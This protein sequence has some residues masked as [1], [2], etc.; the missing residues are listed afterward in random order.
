MKFKFFD[1]LSVLGITFGIGSVLLGNALEG[2][3]INS[4]INIPA[5][6]IVLGG[7]L[8]AT[9]LQ[10]P[11]HIFFKSLSMLIWIIR[12]VQIDA[13]KQIEL[14]IYWSH[15]ARKSGLL[16]L[17]DEVEATTDPFIK[18]ALQLL[19]DGKNE[20]AITQALELDISVKEQRDYQAAKVFEAMGGYSPT[21]GILGAVLGLIHVMQN[22]GNTELLGSGIATAFVATI[23]GVAL[24]NLIFLPIAHKLKSHIFEAIQLKEMLTLGIICIANNENPQNIELQLSGY[25]HNPIMK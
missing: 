18:K 4:L 9:L 20:N 24:A 10:F 16:A 2:G 19:V 23:Y 8:G 25:L 5:F 22:L 11:P 15:Q 17:E 1:F 12:P 3:Q 21:L 13:E 6:I 7:T 14:I